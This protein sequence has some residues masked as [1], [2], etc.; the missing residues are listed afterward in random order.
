MVF[1]FLKV[2]RRIVIEFT[3]ILSRNS[4]KSHVTVVV[5][6]FRL[7]YLLNGYGINV[8]GSTYGYSDMSPNLSPISARNIPTVVDRVVLIIKRRAH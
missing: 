8:Y 1:F 7:P 5:Y 2:F 6:G 3:V 4:R